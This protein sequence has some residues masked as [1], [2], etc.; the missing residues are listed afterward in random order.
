MVIFWRVTHPQIDR[1]AHRTGGISYLY[2]HSGWLTRIP[3]IDM[4]PENLWGMRLDRRHSS[5]MS[6]YEKATVRPEHLH[7]I[8]LSIA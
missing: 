4:G 6:L 8:T 2:A 5:K 1:Y 3:Y 7:R